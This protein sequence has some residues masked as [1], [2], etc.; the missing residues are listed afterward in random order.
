MDVILP[1]FMAF[2]VS[3][4]M[5]PIVINLCREF[6]LYDRHS[7][8]K[9][10]H[11]NIARVGGF[12][13]FFSFITT[14]FIL[15]FP[16]EPTPF[17]DIFYLA[18]ML[19]AFLTGLVDDF[20]PIRARYK[21]LL[22]ILA[23][24]LAASSGLSVSPIAF[25]DGAQMDLG[26]TAPVITVLFIV[27][28]INAVNLFDGMDGLASGVI[29]IANMFLLVF[30]LN[31]GKVFPALILMAFS[32]AVLG[33]YVFNF[34]GARIFMGDSGAYLLGF[35]YATVPLMESWT[36][37]LFPQLVIPAVMVLAIPLVDIL[38]VMVL[39]LV[40]GKHIFAPDM[41]HVHHRLLRLGFSTNAV[42][43]ILYMATV[44]LGL[45]VSLKLLVPHRY[46]L[47]VLAIDA[48]VIV[49]FFG[50]LYLAE[51]NILRRFLPQVKNGKERDP[52][53]R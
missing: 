5:I 28:V 37:R 18:G 42:L 11:G 15:I 51:K 19:T 16:G 41:N 40:K 52:S 34:P 9:L 31:T 48:V 6:R 17:K 26:I 7:E 4:L 13:I 12:A 45:I 23:G 10:H 22:Q 32:G 43:C 25:L 38:N 29:F 39:R 14:Y 47:I 2:F 3:I 27:F 44:I 36:P 1:F 53:C 30:A 50:L 20:V 8:R 21:L 49:G 46:A 24:I 33:F 35:L